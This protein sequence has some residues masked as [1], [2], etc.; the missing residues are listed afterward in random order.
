MDWTS[1]FGLIDPALLL[2]VAG[3]W[4]LGYVLKQTPKLPD[5]TIVYIVTVFAVAAVIGMQGLSVQSAIQGVL[6]GAF[7]VYGN[8]VVK[9]TKEGAD[10]DAG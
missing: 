10:N 9:Q 2:V 8:Q 3:C 4:V 7:A 5:W 6:C 1:I